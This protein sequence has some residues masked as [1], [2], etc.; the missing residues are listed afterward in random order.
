M[1]KHSVTLTLGMVPDD[2]AAEHGY[3]EVVTHNLGHGRA[4]TGLRWRPGV[5]VERVVFHYLY[6]R[7][8]PANRGGEYA[9]Q[10]SY[11]KGA[12]KTR[13]EQKATAMRLAAVGLAV[14]A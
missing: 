11:P 7:P 6:G 4:S 14:A 3:G 12:G 1:V 9:E 10:Y 13:A 8:A 5:D 2:W